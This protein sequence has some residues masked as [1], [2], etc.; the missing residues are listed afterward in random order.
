MK[1]LKKISSIALSMMMVMTMGASAFAAD[2]GANESNSNSLTFK[3][4]IVVYNNEST[5]VYGPGIEY[6]YTV[7]P[8][9]VSGKTVTDKGGDTM[10]VKSGVVDGLT[11][12][13][14]KKAT[15]TQNV[16]VA[17]TSGGTVISDTVDLTIN[18]SAF[19]SAGI[20]RYQITETKPADFEDV[21]LTRPDAYKV[22]RYIDVYIKNK[23]PQSETDGKLE[24]FGTVIFFEE[25]DNISANA[26]VT[27]NAITGKAEGFTEAYDSSIDGQGGTA[28]SGMADKYYTY[29]YTLTKS[30]TG[31]MADKTHYFPFAI[32]T[33]GAVAG[34]NFTVTA[35][36]TPNLVNGVADGVAATSTD[37]NAK[38]KDTQ[39]VT[40]KGLPA[41]TSIEVVET[42]NTTDTY[43]VTASDTSG[44]TVKTFVDNVATTAGGTQTT[45]VNPVSNYASNKI[46]EPTALLTATTFVN[47]L[48]EVSPTNVVM[49]FAP[50]LFIL[51]GAMLLLVASRRRKAEQE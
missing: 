25:N 28:G 37:I 10:T 8:V 21:G 35:T 7:S 6:S 14:D 39:T 51:G 9:T 32:K 43:N 38:L 5:T 12:G 44:E 33:S 11:L 47:E 22:S 40:I 17:A 42:N 46:T 2:T 26:E 45:K 30:I 34:Q 27:A 19:P 15:F 3:K 18:P 13:T 23:V 16:E 50:Y 20:Y 48:N 36:E 4:E 31:T 1:H 49:R 24:A 41:N 29:N